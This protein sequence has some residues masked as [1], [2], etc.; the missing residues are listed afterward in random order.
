MQLEQYILFLIIS[1]VTALV[2]AWVTVR[3]SLRR[4]RAERLWERR[5]DAYQAVLGALHRVSRAYA[6]GM[7]ETSLAEPGC[8]NR[9]YTAEG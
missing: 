5:V 9:R 4:F 1:I 6:G 3:L 7:E 2:T 8:D